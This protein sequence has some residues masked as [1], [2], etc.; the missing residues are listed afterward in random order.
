MKILVTGATGAVGHEVLPLLIADSNIDHILTLNIE[1]DI[2]EKDFSHP[3][4]TNI[5]IDQKMNEIV[6][7]FNPDLVLHL[8]A[9]ITSRND[10]TSIEKLVNTNIYFGAQLLDSLKQT[11][12][13]YF[14]NIG[15]FA[16]Y[17]SGYDYV[18][19][20]Y[21]YSATKTAFK[22]ILDYYS[23]LIGFDYFHLIPFTIYGDDNRQKKVINYIIDSI[24]S[25]E[26]IDMTSGEQ[27]LDFIHIKDVAGYIHNFITKIESLHSHHRENF[28][29]GTG[30]GTSIRSLATLVEK[31]YHRPVKVNWG[32][33][34]YRE[35]DVMY[36][37]A[38]IQKNILL[39]DW[40][41]TINL[42]TGI[43][44]YYE[45]HNKEY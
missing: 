37:V 10:S 5:L 38:P 41:P 23:N 34:P 3:K 15:T 20:A 31:I 28:Y 35:K 6:T 11:D 9:Y 12:I 40:K 21:F 27:I 22:S 14:I 18:D 17:R 30:T 29:I 32:K 16:E 19:N 42:E 13:K 1:N 43:R 36:A 26:C 4:V 45:N 7:K 44:Q 33:L 24:D 8:A 39:L 25:K 2:A